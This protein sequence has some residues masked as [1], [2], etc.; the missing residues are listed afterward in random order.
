MH[1]ALRSDSKL[2]SLVI[3]LKRDGESFTKENLLPA[4]SESGIPMYRVGVQRFEIAGFE[5]K[6]HLVY[7]V[8]DLPQQR[9]MEIM[10]A[11]AP[12]VTDLLNKLKS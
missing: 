9:N 6:N 1:L 7:V 4:L 11:L 3:A 5:S 10:T 2:L 12:A 8:S